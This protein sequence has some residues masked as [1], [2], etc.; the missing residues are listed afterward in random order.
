MTRDKK[1]VENKD[2][3]ESILIKI[4]ERNDLKVKTLF[5]WVKGHNKDAGNE[6]ADKLAV[7]GA[8]KG[9]SVKAEALRAED[10]PDEVFEEDF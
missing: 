3:V 8:Q 10:I 9:V 7:N 5:E 4:E 6:E 1:P 2:L